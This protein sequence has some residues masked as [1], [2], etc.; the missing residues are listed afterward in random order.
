[1][2]LFFFFTDPNIMYFMN[3][4]ENDLSKINFKEDNELDLPEFYNTL[5]SAID[6]HNM[7][8]VYELSKIFTRYHFKKSDS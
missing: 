5:S 7:Q 2:I 6:N 1:M 3:E 4:K 8:S